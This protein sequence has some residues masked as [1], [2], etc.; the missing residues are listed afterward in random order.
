MAIDHGDLKATNWIHREGDMRGVLVDLEGVRFL[1]ALSDTR[2]IEGLAQWNA[3]LPD[4]V[5]ARTRRRLFEHYVRR[6]PFTDD[7]PT[8]LRE[9]ARRSLARGHRWT[10]VDCSCGD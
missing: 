3:S 6:V 4:T 2:R 10:G 7:A 5:T 9:V 1:R 8:I